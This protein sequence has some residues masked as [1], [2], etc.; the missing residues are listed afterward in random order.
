MYKILPVGLIRDA[1]RDCIEKEPIASI[2][3]MERASNACFDWISDHFPKENFSF[4]I[5]AGIGNNGGDGLAIAR[6]LFEAGYKVNT[7]VIRFSDKSS[8][9][10]NINLE[11]LKKL[12]AIEEISKGEKLN[13]RPGQDI[14]V[15]AILGSGITRSPEGWLADII[16]SINNS[17]S[18]IIAID[19]PSGLMTDESSINHAKNIVQA[20]IT[21]TLGVHK[22]ALFLPENERFVGDWHFIPIGLRQEFI[23]EAKTRHHYTTIED[24]ES[25]VLP[26]PKFAHKGTY[27]HTL[28]FAGGKGKMGAVVLSAKAALR[29]GCGL[30]SVHT[31]EKQS[32]IIQSSAPEAMI[33]GDAD[34]NFISE[35]PEI[36]QFT[37]IGFGPGCGTDEKTAKVLKNIIQNANQPLVLDADALNIL[38]EN[39]TWLAFLPKNSILT[40]HIGEFKRLNG[41][42]K[43]DFERL[44]DASALAMKHGIIIILKGANTAICAPDGNI[45]FNPTGNPGMAKGG[46]GDVLTGFLAGLLAKGM[47]PLHAA[48]LGVY[49]HGLAGDIAAENLSMEAMKSGD[50]IE[51]LPEAWNAV[52]D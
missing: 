17:E 13:L 23:S 44:N 1:D 52:I 39:K 21:L 50:I 40:P 24:I 29:S 9:D 5:L 3:L 43:N 35:F 45:Y 26:R 47:N 42:S 33:S 41:D 12:S 15:D 51:M 2:D 8:E 34:P 18:P 7:S 48:I 16:H 20:N 19:I 38:A 14:I 36:A 11:R 10:F 49:L 28:I 22:L 37:S 31:P 4:H 46:S 32:H 27:G 6:M 30:V 25:L